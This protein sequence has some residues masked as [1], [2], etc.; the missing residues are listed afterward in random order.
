[1]PISSGGSSS[2][3][4]ESGSPRLSWSL[5]WP[6]STRGGSTSPKASARSSAT[7]PER[8]A[9][10]S[11]PRTTASRPPV[12]VG[13]SPPSSTC[14]PTAP[15]TSARCGCSPRTSGPTTSKRSWPWR[16]G[17]ASGKS[18]RSSRAWLRGPTWRPRCASSPPRRHPG[19]RGRRRCSQPCLSHPGGSTV[20][21]GPHRPARLSR[22]AGPRHLRPDRRR[23]ARAACPPAGGHRAGAG[24]L[25][26][27]VHRGRSDA[28]KAAPRPGA[29]PA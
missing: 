21:P 17:G 28:R 13:V 3:P 6:S 25:P 12:P 11:T 29:P 5:T 23:S 10:P 7:A 18:R 15:G 26:S 9:S 14:W 22:H 1:M 4:G 16:K 24:A 27:A 8:C 20:W 2:S 19:L